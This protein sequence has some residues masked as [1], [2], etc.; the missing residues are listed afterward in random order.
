MAFD[1]KVISSN[2]SDR[3]A[4]A[5]HKLNWI[6]GK[7]PAIIRLR[8]HIARSLARTA[9]YDFCHYTHAI[10]GRN[11]GMTHFFHLSSHRRAQN[12]AI[13]CAS[14]S[15]RWLFQD[16]SPSDDTYAPR[17]EILKMKFI[18][19][20]WNEFGKQK[21]TR[22]FPLFIFDAL[23]GIVSG[24]EDVYLVCFEKFFLRLFLSGCCY[25]FFRQINVWSTVCRHTHNGRVGDGGRA[26]RK[27]S[28]RC[29]TASKYTSITTN[30]M[31]RTCAKNQTA[32]NAERSNKTKETAEEWQKKKKRV[33][34]VSSCQNK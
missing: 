15:N 4:W 22:K 11:W 6:R 13:M 32:L 2:G 27:K 14:R 5:I 20:K 34:R 33:C 30:K 25:S 7:R 8:T 17:D 12:L 16:G 29:L 21:A 23:S 18:E 28:K 26:N 9:L 10:A 24:I 19:T 3:R 1:Y 31:F